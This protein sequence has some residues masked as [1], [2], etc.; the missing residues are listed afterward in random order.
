[1]ESVGSVKILPT[2]LARN[3]SAIG[4]VRPSVR[5]FPLYFMNQLTTFNLDFCMCADYD[6]SLFWIES[7]SQDL[8]VVVNAKCVLVGLPTAECY[9]YSSMAVVVGLLCDVFSC[10]IAWQYMRRGEQACIYHR[11]QCA[12]NVSRHYHWKLPRSV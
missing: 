11:K 4:R 1:V 7:R 9:E 8:K 10:N 3:G 5:L 6:H 2:A 12:I